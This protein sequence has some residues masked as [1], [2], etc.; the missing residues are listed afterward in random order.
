MHRIRTLIVD[1]EPRIRRGIERLIVSCGERFEVVAVLS[2]GKEA[3]DYLHQCGGAVDLVISDVKMPEMDGLTF[4]KEARAHYAFY[5]LFISGYDDFDYLRA[6]LREGAIDYVLKPV[7]RE[8]FR[9][10]MAEIE[11]RIAGDRTRQLKLGELEQQ[12]GR[13]KRTRQTQALSYTTSPGVDLT[14]LGYWVEEFPRGRYQLMYVSLDVLPVKSRSYTVKDWEAYFYALENILEELVHAHAAQTGGSGWCWRG[15]QSDFWT[16]LHLSEEGAAE[17]D[18]LTELADRIRSAFRLYTPFSAS[19]ACCEAIEDLYLLPE[20]KRQC[21]SLIQY[22]LV[23][24]GNRLFRPKQ[25][26]GDAAESSGTAGMLPPAADKIRLA[27]EQAR[28]DEALAQMKLFF[29]Q[30]EKR[31][32][33][34]AILPAVQNLLILI[35]SASL[36]GS[37]HSGFAVSLEETFDKLQ[38][39]AHLHELKQEV[40]KRI[41]EAVRGIEETRT[42]SRQS[43][44][45]DQAKAW[46]REH[47]AGELTIKRIAD[48]VHMNPTYFC[49]CFKVQCGETV[50]DYVT[51]M[52]M[53]FAKELLQDPGLRLQELSVQVGYQDVKYFSRLFK[54]WSGATPS[55]YREQLAA[56]GRLQSKQA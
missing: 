50:L 13:L 46:I 11:E 49:E 54:Q 55:Q 40:Q 1:D 32:S 47:L 18:A 53:E 23:E 17:H 56:S 2:D 35:H 31:E 4:V 52:R 5:S 38:R 14:R 42:G 15:G 37:G 24:G 22:R 45:V 19:I 51:R 16:L 29:E 12:A 39:A 7:D 21:L 26:P 3:L 36:T 34:A 41:A 27:V 8:Q 48:H 44:P 9:L 20:A 30:V 28:L 25:Y 43:T 33:P 10:R 6:A